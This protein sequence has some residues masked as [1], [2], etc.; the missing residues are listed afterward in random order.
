MDDLVD[1][2]RQAEALHLTGTGT[3]REQT[4]GVFADEQVAVAAPASNQVR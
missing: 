2:E 1:V 3:H 4:L